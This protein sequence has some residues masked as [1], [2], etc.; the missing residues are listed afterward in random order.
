[1]HSTHLEEI[2]VLLI[3]AVC[4]VTIFRRFHLS[5]M[6]GYLFAGLA[7]GPHGIGIIENVEATRTIAELG[8]VFLLFAIGLEL[9]V[10]RLRAM[11]VQVFG[12]GTAQVVLTS[13][14]IGYIAY[15]LNASIEAAIV[16]GGGLALSSTAVVLQYLADNNEQATQA[17]RVSLA[18]LILQD[19]MVVPL[20]IMVPL[21]GNDAMSISGAL[22]DSTIKASLALIVIFLI[23]KWLLRPLFQ[24]VAKTGSQELFV[25]TTLLVVLGAAFGTEQAGLSLALGAF[26][27]GLLVA[28]TEYRAQVET[29]I[30]PFKGLLMG[31]FFM[32]V[33]MSINLAILVNFWELILVLCFTLMLLKVVIVGMLARLFGF[34]TGAAVQSGLILSQG[35]EFAFVLFGLAITHH[36]MPAPTGQVLFVVISVTMALTPLVARIGRYI[37][38]NLDNRSSVRIP[39]AVIKNETL[40][41]DNHI[42]VAGYGRVGQTVCKLLAAEGLTNFIAIDDDAD[43]VKEAQKRGAPVYYGDVRSMNLLESCGI[44]R[45][46][47][48]AFTIRDRRM[49]KKMI[50]E[51]HKKYRSTPIVARAWDRAHAQELYEAGAT[52]AL[53]EAFESSLQLGAF[54]LRT[55][56]VVD[57]EVERVLKQFRTEEYPISLV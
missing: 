26:V 14:A 2:V 46:C 21:L 41:L 44:K 43:V 15:L 29:D 17:G 32:S 51:V 3:A 7:I 56:G 22:V 39:Q 50:S 16:I 57:Q 5:P 48:I 35:S 10:D 52:I 47:L 11:R 18:V 37:K 54:I 34:G 23:G 53:A 12:L 49:T 31:L 33:G 4:I 24:L 38:E 36:V 45:A 6:L 20:L 19:L 27:A 8:V 55:H 25:A 30:M 28:E 42:I 1:M 13:V 9:T 40:D